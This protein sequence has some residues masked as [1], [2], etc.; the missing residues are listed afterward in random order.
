MPYLDYNSTTPVDDRVIQAMLPTFAESFGNPSSQNH[1]TGRI[2][3]DLVENARKSVADIVGMKPSD[4][5]F[6]SG[7][8]EANNWIFYGLS[9]NKGRPLRMFVSAIE[10][11][12]VLEPCRHLSEQGAKLQK[13]P[14]TSDGIV[15]LR[16]LDGML[17]REKEKPD[18]VSVMAA[19]SET[20]VIQPIQDIAD[21][22]HAYGALVHCDATQIIGKIPFDAQELGVDFVTFSSHKIY[23]PKGCGALVATRHARKQI[24]AMLYGGGQENDMR[25]GTLNVTGIVGFGKACEIAAKEGLADCPRQEKLRDYFESNMMRLISDVA[26][27]GKNADRIPNT[28]NVRI[29]DTIAEA[30]IVNAPKVEIATGSACSSA[31]IEPSHVLTAMGLSTDEANASIRISIGRQTTQQDID[32]AIDAIAKAVQYVRGKE[33][34]IA[35]A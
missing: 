19:N 32:T 18:I 10:H 25:S 14:V 26:V 31:A 30:V 27:N 2:G 16:Q 4:V 15:D 35:G 29:S 34:E 20:G 11:K 7:A 22:A 24:R 33:A 17:L 13:I 12:S 3:R 6:T 5:I 23:G 9:M 1:D 28:S 21:R 8:T